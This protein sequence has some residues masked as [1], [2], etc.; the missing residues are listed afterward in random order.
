MLKEC[1]FKVF[2]NDPNSSGGIDMRK[3]PQNKCG[4]C[5]GVGEE[6]A[7][8][9]RCD[10]FYPTQIRL[11]SIAGTISLKRDIFLKSGIG[12]PVFSEE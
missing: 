12:Q 9:A 1:L 8:Q 6:E 10:Y 5:P 7:L 11:P 3:N 2:Y 4:E